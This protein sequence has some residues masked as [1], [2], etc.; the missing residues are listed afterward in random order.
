MA[1]RAGY[2]TMAQVHSA[3]S[4]PPEWGGPAVARAMKADLEAASL[5]VPGV[6]LAVAAHGRVES[7]Q[8]FGLLAADRA[9]R[10]STTSMFHA[11]SMS[12]LV[13]AL[14]VLRLVS[15]G[16]VNL[17]E[18][19]NG[20]LR[21]WQ[22]PD[23]G[24]AA[25]SP[26]TLRMLLSHQSGIVDAEG[27]FDVCPPELDEPE[28]LDVLRGR[29]AL[30]PHPV[31]VTHVPG[32]QFSYSDA[33]YCVVEQAL[34]D[35]TLTPFDDVMRQL[36]LDPLDMTRSR[37]GAPVAHS[38]DTD[39]AAGHDR[40]GAVIDGRHPR[41]PYL[42]A[43]GL[44]STPTDLARVLSELHQ[45]LSGGGRLGLAREHAAGMVRGQASTPWAGLGTFVGGTDRAR[46]TSLGWGVG[47]QC[48]LRAYPYSGDAVLVMTSCDPGRPQDEA[49]TG[50]L[51]HEVETTRDWARQ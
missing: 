35:V 38:D 11:A 28:L 31:R 42:A 20:L 51:V 27:T 10:V 16:H 39:V 30:N 49:L 34:T 12:K 26:V 5:R 9:E 17:D 45:A 7:A 37:F 3:E 48:M 15:Q 21:S 33:G 14:G 43:A 25:P 4:S 24:A 44:W 41:Y 29:S 8:A 40:G 46:I 6:S 50:H 2:G 47:F 13:T 32:S 19:V 23:D 1:A 36:V 18:D 22:V